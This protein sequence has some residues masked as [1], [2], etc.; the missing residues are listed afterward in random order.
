MEAALRDS[1]DVSKVASVKV[2]WFLCAQI[3]WKLYTYG[4]HQTDTLNP[5]GSAR[6]LLIEFVSDRVYSE[7]Q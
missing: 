7:T 3:I 6:V 2:A 5:Y 1:A 4:W